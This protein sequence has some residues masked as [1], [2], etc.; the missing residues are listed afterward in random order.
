MP[1]AILI[2]WLLAVTAVNA[3]GT[4]DAYLDALETEARAI[5]HLENA[6]RLDT[7]GGTRSEA[8]MERK[9]VTPGLTMEEFERELDQRFGGTSMIYQRLSDEAKQSI[10]NDYQDDNRIS[11]IRRNVAFSL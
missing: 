10:Y 3:Q 1:S 4:G 11:V 7:S 9:Y 5:T 6:E 2:L 8:V